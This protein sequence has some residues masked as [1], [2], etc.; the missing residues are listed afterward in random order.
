MAKEKWFINESEFDD[1]Q[2]K[3]RDLNPDKSFVIQGPAGSGKTVLAI[4][5]A[6]SLEQN[7]KDYRFVVFTRALKRFIEDGVMGY[8]INPSRIMTYAKWEQQ[9]CPSSDYM[10]V[11]EAQDFTKS[12]II[13]L[14]EK[15]NKSIMLFGDSKQQLYAHKTGT[16]EPTVSMEQISDFLQF[17]LR[18]LEKN[19]RLPIPIARFAQEILKNDDLARKCVKEGSSKPIVAK[20]NNWEEE[21]NFIIKYIRTYNLTDVGIFVPENDDVLRIFNY[22]NA[23]GLLCE[24]KYSMGSGDWKNS[25]DFTTENPKITTYHSS[26]GVQFET[27]FI[28]MCETC[29]E[30][31]RAS[32]YVAATRPYRDLIVTYS[33]TLSSFIN[34]IRRS[35]WEEK[36][37]PSLLTDKLPF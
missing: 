12:E 28:P 33:K 34:G 1:E 9:G 16:A 5:K 35:L 22:M 19:Y 10:I 2:Y 23:N 29:D 13:L 37:N 7:E 31:Y 36:K 18:K 6:I 30:F 21:L 27:V 14:R 11:D 8:D 4:S 25:L 3:I 20:F 26:K 32:L 17:P 15:A 24:A